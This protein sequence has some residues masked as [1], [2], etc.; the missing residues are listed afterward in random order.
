MPTTRV[1]PELRRREYGLRTNVDR[2]RREVY[3]QTDPSAALELLEQLAKAEEE[4]DTVEQQRIT[5]Q[6]QDPDS[7]LILDTK[8]TSTRRGPE[9]TGLEAKI[10]LNMAQVP[11]SICHLLDAAITP[12]LTCA[13]K[14][15]TVIE[16]KPKRR[17]R[18][19][20]YIDGY[21]AKAV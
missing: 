17:I 6:E 3:Q 14:A 12:L 4:L 5:T 21:S 8:D 19:S 11:T 15:T 13:V 16:R 18:I 10:Y 20:S 7:G 9:T 2:L 1:S